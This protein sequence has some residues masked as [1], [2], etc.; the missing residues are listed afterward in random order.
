[1]LCLG[2]STLTLAQK[3]SKEWKKYETADYTISY[4][5]TWTLDDSGQLGTQFFLFS[6]V[7]SAN[8]TFRANV[9]LIIQ[10]LSGLKLSLEQYASLSEDQ[11]KNLITD[12]AILES[13]NLGG[14]PEIHRLIYTGRQGVHDLKFYQH[15]FIVKDKAY[16]LTFTSQEERFEYYSKVAEEILTSFSLED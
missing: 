4:P 5:S 10:D 12:S 9:N 15:Y 2:F 3:T 6:P 13:K 1:M 16:V 8:S 11:I 7:E 14:E